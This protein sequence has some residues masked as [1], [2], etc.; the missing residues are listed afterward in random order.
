MGQ[1]PEQLRADIAQTRQELDADLDLLGEKVSPEKV[2]ERRVDATKGRFTDARDKVMGP[3]GG[4]DGSGLTESVKGGPDAA[5]SKAAGQPF[6]AGLIAFGAGWLLSSLLPASQAEIHAADKLRDNVEEPV[7][8]QLQASANEIKDNV[9]PAA[10]QAA[11]HVKASATDAAQ[12][13]KDQAH[14]SKSEVQGQAQGAADT[15]KD[16]AQD[17]KDQVKNDADAAS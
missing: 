2:I 11:E 17:G 5:R 10:E 9:Q 3:S 14:D 6:V 7:K 16:S 1:D 12:T 4:S 15:V 8:D 13:V